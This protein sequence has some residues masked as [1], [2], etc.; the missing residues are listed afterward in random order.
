MLPFIIYCLRYSQFVISRQN[1]SE[2]ADMAGNGSISTIPTKNE[3]T[4]NNVLANSLSEALSPSLVELKI[5]E[6]RPIATTTANVTR[7]NVINFLFYSK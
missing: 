2:H 5:D 4:P 7:M 1:R 6:P 3:T